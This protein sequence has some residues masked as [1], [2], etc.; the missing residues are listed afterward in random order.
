MLYLP[1]DSCN[2]Q[3]ATFVMALRMSRRFKRGERSVASGPG[4]SGWL[5]AAASSS[6]DCAAC[7]G[8]FW[9]GAR[10]ERATIVNATIVNATSNAEFFIGPSGLCKKGLPAFHYD[11]QL[12]HILGAELRKRRAHWTRSEAKD[13]HHFL[14]DRNLVSLSASA[15]FIER[16]HVSVHQTHQGGRITRGSSLMKL[17][18]QLWSHRCNARSVAANADAVVPGHTIVT[19]SANPMQSIANAVDNLLVSPQV[20]LAVFP[21]RQRGNT[22]CQLFNPCRARVHPIAAVNEQ[23]QRCGTTDLRIVTG[24]TLVVGIGIIRRQSQDG[25]GP[26]PR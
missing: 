14:H 16:E 9:H 11:F 19:R 2:C 13:V 12:T 23:P 5:P 18:R 6:I 26:C 24:Q 17:Q 25:I 15:K 21:T 1:S 3:S 8:G 10:R 22:L 20:A 7:A 4:S